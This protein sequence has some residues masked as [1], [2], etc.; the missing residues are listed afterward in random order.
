MLIAVMRFHC[1]KVLF[2]CFTIT[3][4][5]NIVCHTE[6]SVIQRFIKY[7]FHCVEVASLHTHLVMSDAFTM[8]LPSLLKSQRL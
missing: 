7:N 8:N 4:A 2:Q 1:I 5:R 6:D 3:G